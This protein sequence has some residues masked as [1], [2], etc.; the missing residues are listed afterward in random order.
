MQCV[1]N[2]HYVILFSKLLLFVASR[3]N[4]HENLTD[5][6]KSQIILLSSQLGQI[7]SKTTR[8]GVRSQYAVVRTN[9]IGSKKGELVSR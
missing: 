1:H 5:F 6:G 7:I 2:I 9:H 3:K 4:R 8:F